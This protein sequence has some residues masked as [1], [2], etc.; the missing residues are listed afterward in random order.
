MICGNGRT[1]DLVAESTD[2]TNYLLNMQCDTWTDGEP[3]GL[4]LSCIANE[5]TGD[6]R[7]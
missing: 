2:N 7:V 6:T 3:P 5:G 1:P 4:S